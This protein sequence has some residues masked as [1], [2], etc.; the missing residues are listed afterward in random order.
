METDEDGVAIDKATVKDRTEEITT[1]T[2]KNNV[3]L[4]TDIDMSK[5]EISPIPDIQ[6]T[7]PAPDDTP[8]VTDTPDT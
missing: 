8:I 1:I 4:V 6:I 5:E 7:E 2:V 3:T